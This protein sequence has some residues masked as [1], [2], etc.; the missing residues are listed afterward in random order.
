MR[1][2]T[3]LSLQNFRRNI[4][5][6]YLKILSFSEPKASRRLKRL[7]KLATSEIRLFPISKL[8]EKTEDGKQR[9]C[10]VFKKKFSE[11]HRRCNGGLHMEKC[12]EQWHSK[13]LVLY[14]GWWTYCSL[15]QP[16]KNA[17][18]WVVPQFLE[19]YAWLCVAY[20]YPLGKNVSIFVLPWVCNVFTSRMTFG[21]CIL[22]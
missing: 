14:H 10:A 12:F 15:F 3:Q 20:S 13:K 17:Y 16:C 6:S 5:R 18:S 7:S 22:L 21:H 8:L 19:G 11:Q 4:A 1:D 9:M 2:D